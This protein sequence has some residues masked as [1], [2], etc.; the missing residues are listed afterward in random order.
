MISEYKK[1]NYSW[2]SFT[3]NV[4]NTGLEVLEDCK[5]FIYPE[6]NKLRELGGYLQVMAIITFFLVPYMNAKC[7]LK[8]VLFNLMQMI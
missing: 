8:R 5:I 1:I 2:S 3:I 4:K 6:V 7:L